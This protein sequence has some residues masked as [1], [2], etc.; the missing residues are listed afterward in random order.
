MSHVTTISLR[1]TD[2]EAL[3][4]ACRTLGLE[5]PT[6]GSV[7]FYD[8]TTHEGLVVRLPDYVYPAV[9]DGDGHIRVDHFEGRW[10]APERLD[11]LMQRYGCE[12]VR[13]EATRAGHSVVE[14]RL[15]NGSVRMTVTPRL[16]E[17]PVGEAVHA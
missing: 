11:E 2:R 15:D 1:V 10:G 3:N 6:E 4:R 13:L 9:V 12:K 5:E 16:T 8:G 17:M 7:K 14:R